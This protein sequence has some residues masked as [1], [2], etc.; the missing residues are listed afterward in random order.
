M[1]LAGETEGFLTEAALEAMGPQIRREL[2][3]WLHGGNAPA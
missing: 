1:H 3:T 2:V